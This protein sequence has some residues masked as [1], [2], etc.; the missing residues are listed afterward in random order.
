MSAKTI[1]VFCLCAALAC[2]WGIG[3]QPQTQTSDAVLA[4]QAESLAAGPLAG[5]VCF[6]ASPDNAPLRGEVGHLVGRTF[7][8][9]K[10]P[11]DNAVLPF[12]WRMDAAGLPAPESFEAAVTPDLRMAVFAY[13]AAAQDGNAAAAQRLSD[14]KNSG[15]NVE[16]LRA[17]GAALAAQCRKAVCAA[18]AKGVPEETYTP[19]ETA[20]FLKYRLQGEYYS[21]RHLAFM[22]QS[23]NPQL[24]AAMAIIFH[25]VKKRRELRVDPPGAR[26]TDASPAILAASLEGADMGDAV[27]AALQKRLP[28]NRAQLL[29]SAKITGE[30][31]VD[32]SLAVYVYAQAAHAGDKR[33]QAELD[34]L[35][36]QGKNVA[37]LAREG[38]EKARDLMARYPD[39]VQP[40]KNAAVAKL[41]NHL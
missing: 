6:L 24:M 34:A 35:S 41:G 21:A 10:A 28:H 13:A 12:D 16:S 30:P 40:D 38:G 8:N 18:L 9:G 22:L 39:A 19:L 17:Q 3:G 26:V 1:A 23:K 20:F 36:K 25:D 14:L 32:L 11:E 33:A 2:A 27:L 29:D 7:E 15:E 37:A 5:P 4:A 31:L